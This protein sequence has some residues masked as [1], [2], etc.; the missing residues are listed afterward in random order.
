MSALDL[1]SWVVIFG[2]VITVVTSVVSLIA[3]V[4]NAGKSSARLESEMKALGKGQGELR[5]DINGLTRRIDSILETLIGATLFGRPVKTSSSESPLA[6]TELGKKVSKRLDVPSLVAGH[7]SKLRKQ[8]DGQV[9]YDIQALSLDFINN[10]FR[11]TKDVERKLK[12]CAF[13]DGISLFEV[14]IVLAIELRDQ[15]MKQAR[16]QEAS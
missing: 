12:Q 7:A 4:R 10:K 14:H 16:E 2:V 13:D 15:L 3:W 8:A 9:D 11:P 6:L 5:D 1:Q